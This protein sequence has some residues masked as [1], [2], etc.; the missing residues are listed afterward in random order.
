MDAGLILLLSNE[1]TTNLSHE[2]LSWLECW[3][4]MCWD[5][6]I[7]DDDDRDDFTPEALERYLKQLQE[8]KEQKQREMKARKK[9]LNLPHK[10][11]MDIDDA[12][13]ILMR[14]K[15]GLSFRQIAS[16][17]KCSPQTV[18]NRYNRAKGK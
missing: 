17:M 7:F 15:Q 10:L 13:L 2:A 1:L 12:K 3:D 18:I 4:V 9:E 11:R 14:D 5:D 16:I 6:D 8:Q